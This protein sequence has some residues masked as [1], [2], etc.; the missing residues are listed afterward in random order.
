MTTPLDTATE[1]PAAAH[2]MLS[3]AQLAAQE[4]TAHARPSVLTTSWL[5]TNGLTYG[6]RSPVPSLV[7]LR[8]TKIEAEVAEPF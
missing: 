7:L 4:S 6:R 5:R 8:R 1:A 2:S 3:D